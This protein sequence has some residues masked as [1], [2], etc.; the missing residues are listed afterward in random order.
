[1]SNKFRVSGQVDTD[2]VLSSDKGRG[3]RSR[4]ISCREE[5]SSTSRRGIRHGKGGKLASEITEKG[6]EV[7]PPNYVLTKK[8]GPFPKGIS[9]LAHKGD[10]ASE[11][12]SQLRKEQ[13]YAG[14]NVIVGEIEAGATKGGADS[15]DNDDASYEVESGGSEEDEDDVA[16][17]VNGLV[18]DVTDED[19]VAFDKDRT[20]RAIDNQ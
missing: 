9:D 18:K 15:E 3:N 19:G 12:E 8:E 2:K 17:S 11:G 13:R 6:A 10:K 16:S 7:K 5:L 4:S 20:I 1:M 14:E